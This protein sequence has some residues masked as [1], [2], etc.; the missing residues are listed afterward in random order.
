MVICGLA[1]W[2]VYLETSK[3]DLTRFSI[4]VASSGTN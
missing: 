4:E 3:S 2:Q 1:E